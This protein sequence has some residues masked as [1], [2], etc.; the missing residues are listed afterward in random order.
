MNNFQKP[1]LAVSMRSFG[2]PALPGRHIVASRP[3]NSRVLRESAAV[4]PN[5][6]EQIRVSSGMSLIWRCKRGH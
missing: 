3:R 6:A 5:L 2:Q 1:R 4:R